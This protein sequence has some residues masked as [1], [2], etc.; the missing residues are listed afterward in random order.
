MY[1]YTETV[2]AERFRFTEVMYSTTCRNLGIELDSLLSQVIPQRRH[3]CVTNVHVT[4]FPT[5]WYLTR[6]YS[7]DAL[8]PRAV[9][10]AEKGTPWTFVGDEITMSVLQLAPCLT[11]CSQW[12]DQFHGLRGLLLA[13]VFPH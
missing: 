2:G 5:I 9:I 7:A 3:L 10:A 13:Q 6:A 12:H 8:Q 4:V 11:C 1:T